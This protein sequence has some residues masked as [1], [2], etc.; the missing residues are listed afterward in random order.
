MARP[1]AAL[2]ALALALILAM[3][4]WGCGGPGG[5]G[6]ADG[7]GAPPSG[8][9]D[10]TGVIVSVDG[11]APGLPGPGEAVGSILVAAAPGA[12]PGYDRASVSINAET[13]IFIRERGAEPV[14]ASA[15]ALRV[16]R[17]AEVWFSGPAAESYPVQAPAGAVCV[18]EEEAPDD[19]FRVKEENAAALMGIPGVVGV[20]IG[21]AAG[22]MCI[23]VYLENPS[24][25]LKS[26]IPSELGG[27]PVVT[28][29]TGAIAPQ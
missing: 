17:Q 3:T 9:P 29:F 25:E 15:A 19:I 8:P 20:G 12:A 16:G 5:S 1:R 14:P 24:P 28:R 11:Y 13:R 6:G 4:S 22:E 2:A 10:I 18:L 23:V 26:R 21:G 27:Y 7:G